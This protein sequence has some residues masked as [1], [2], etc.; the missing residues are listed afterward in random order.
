MQTW[1]SRNPAIKEQECTFWNYKISLKQKKVFFDLSLEPG[2]TEDCGD[3][4]TKFKRDYINSQATD[5]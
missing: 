2:V 1:Y 4:I 3:N 5:P